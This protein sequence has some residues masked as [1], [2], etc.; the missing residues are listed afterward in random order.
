MEFIVSLFSQPAIMVGIMALIGL[1]AL[2]NL[3]KK[4][5]MVL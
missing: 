2:K 3:C 4:L 1:I 5:L